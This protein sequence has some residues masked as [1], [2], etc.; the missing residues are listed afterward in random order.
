VVISRAGKVEAL[1]SS[2]DIPFEGKEILKDYFYDSEIT[3]RDFLMANPRVERKFNYFR[4][5]LSSE[6][7]QLL[8][9]GTSVVEF[10]IPLLGEFLRLVAPKTGGGLPL[11]GVCCPLCGQPWPEN[12]EIPEGVT[13]VPKEDNTLPRY[14]GIIIDA[15]RINL[16]PCLFLKVLDEENKEVYGPGFVDEDELVNNGIVQYT[17]SL[18][19]AYDNERA[20]NLPL[21]INPLRSSG[22]NRSDIII[23]SLDAKRLHSSAHNLK[24][25]NRCRVVVVLPK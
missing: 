3:I 4:P 10:R 14:T 6:E 5:R 13:L 16:N 12:K 11:G 2:Q 22:K 1:I 20:G 23:S 21:V 18:K 8:S 9:D 15:R 24:L 7:K 19:S 17:Y 25:L